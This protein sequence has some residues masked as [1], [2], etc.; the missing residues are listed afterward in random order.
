M[1]LKALA[2]IALV[3]S[4]ANVASAQTV[5]ERA[6]CKLT[7]TAANKTIYEGT[8]KVT[9]SMSGAN[10]IFSVKMGDAEPFMFAGVRGQRNWMHGPEATQFTD[11]PNGGIF[12]WGDFAL[13]VAESAAAQTATSQAIRERATCKLTNTAANKTVYEGTCKVT[14]SMSGA[15]TI[16]SV[17]LGNAE[18]M[19]FAGVRGQRN[20]MHGPEATQFTDA[21]N[22]GIFRWGDFALVV[23]E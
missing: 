20:W 21:P 5:Q 17:K 1:F 2:G 23:A 9:Q 4:L 3:L 22:G 16:F 12:R 11:A 14:Q 18:P 13:V 7:N 19:V 8:C 10:T 15:N 6:T